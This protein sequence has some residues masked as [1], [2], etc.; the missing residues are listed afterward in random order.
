MR[1]Q[2]LHYKEY[3][4][5]ENTYDQ[6]IFF[7][8]TSLVI[9]DPSLVLVA[10]LDRF[11]L[12][13]WLQNRED[14]K[15]PVYE[16]TQSFAMSEEMLYLIITL[17]SDP[18]YTSGLSSEQQ[19]R[20][21]IVHHLCLAPL[22]YSELLRRLSERFSDDP[23]LEL[24]LEQV[25][26][27]KHPVGVTDQG[28]Y[29][30]KEDC[31]D[32]VNPY[33]SRYSRNQR[34]EAD[35]ILREKRKKLGLGEVI[36]P[37]RL[38]ITRGP[39]VSLTKTLGCEVLHRI[40]FLALQH[41]RARGSHFSEV[42][43]DEALQLLILALVEESEGIGNFADNVVM[44]EKEDEKNLV[45]LLVKI[46]DDVT[47][48]GLKHK[49]GWSLDRLDELI[50]GEKVSG[51]RKVVDENDGVKPEKAALDARRL[52]AKARQAAIMEQFSR[53]QHAFLE[54][55][56]NVIDDDED[57]D[58]DD[59]MGVGGTKV[60]LGSCIVCQDELDS[61]QPFGSLAFVQTSNF[62]RLTPMGGE[63]LDFQSEVLAT[64]S[65]LDH[66]ASS[67]RPFGIASKK[68]AV[69]T[70]DE[71]GDGISRGFPQETQSGLHASACGH[72][73]HLACFETYYQSLEQR[74]HVQQTRC[75]PESTER[76]EFICPLCK[77]LGN[78]LLP[79]SVETFELPLEKIDGS[80]LAQWA[81][82]VVDP[83]HHAAV[84]GVALEEIDD[85]FSQMRQLQ[86]RGGGPQTVTGLGAW[87]LGVKTGSR[88]SLRQPEA[89]KAGENLMIGRLLAVTSALGKEMGSNGGLLPNDLMAYTISAIEVASRGHNESA[90]II[91]EATTRMLQSLLQ[92]LRVLVQ[93]QTGE[94]PY[95]NTLAAIAI[96]PHMGGIFATDKRSP[97][98]YKIN[99]LATLI[100]TAAIVPESFHQVAAFCFYSELVKTFFRVVQFLEAN[101]EVIPY[102][103]DAGD[104]AFADYIALAAI[105]SHLLAP[106]NE[107]M[108]S[109]DAE[110]T[111]GKYIYSAMLPFLRRA[112][113]LQSVIFGPTTPL[114]TSSTESELSRLLTSLRIP[115]PSLILRP[116]AEGQPLAPGASALRA[117]LA[118]CVQSVP[119]WT[120][121]IGTPA[122]FTLDSVTGLPYA[123]PDHILA[124]AGPLQHPAIYELVGLSSQLSTLAAEGI[125][126]ECENCG[127]VPEEPAICLLCGQLVCNQS[128]CCMD[129]EEEAQHGE[130]NMHMWT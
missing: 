98:F 54:S 33:F 25:A 70:D 9:L 80:D 126:R 10:I 101:D 91:P 34:E 122:P 79:A 27:F 102:Q 35:K 82:I 94:T 66:D 53:A 3:A 37:K 14:Y 5:R 117:H 6:D 100:E 110:L 123:I 18:T 47:F 60:S 23:S 118:A 69:N 50:G 85:F 116:T 76:K 7:L 74:H 22:P 20:R 55:S 90:S 24:I 87:E 49:L 78:A 104:S 61:S 109:P 106:S 130:C 44:S 58:G 4:L 30:L 68:I 57:D 64:P 59:P 67:I 36:V 114:S 42:L 1:A 15:H 115:H 11:L 13:D 51:L 119:G 52:A 88:L 127:R 43:V 31:F 8:Q 96:A 83:R 99:P 84:R 86:R 16:P 2:Q 120:Q 95:S 56:E 62:I 108:N 89:F 40:V 48:K 113:I 128:F 124:G 105:R 45:K 17:V 26:K 121:Y 81:T 112:S 97:D 93:I 77:S 63:N 107:G 71:S 92:T 19:L 39:F 75:H 125:K 46:E 12:L 65:S 41:G 129:G 73:M 72:M 29:S 32:E 103:G 111:I 38:E 28:T 21:E